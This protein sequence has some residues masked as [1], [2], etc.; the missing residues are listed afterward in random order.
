MPNIAHWAH[1]LILYIYPLSIIPYKVYFARI[2]FA[3]S[4]FCLLA[5]F[6]VSGSCTSISLNVPTPT[7]SNI[8]FIETAALGI[9]CIC[10]NLIPYK[11][12]T[13]L[14][15][16]NANDLQNQIDNLL[17]NKEN[18]M[19]VVKNHRN[20]VDN[21]DKN[22]PK[23][24]WLEN[25]IDKWTELFTLPQRTLAFDLTKKPEQPQQSNKITS[26]DDIKF[27]KE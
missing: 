5:S 15:F 19:D 23:G 18:Y 17:G 24:W 16:N 10:Q 20:I 26:V 6:L 1:E 13:N 22:S 21:G 7:K 25:N 3:H 4:L 12:Y 9:P 2:I 11:D 27:T 14:L 8:K